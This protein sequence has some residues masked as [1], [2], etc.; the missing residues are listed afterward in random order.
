M[1]E[2]NKFVNLATEIETLST[3]YYSNLETVKTLANTNT[4][5][6]EKLSEMQKLIN[7][8]LVMLKKNMVRIED[9]TEKKVKTSSKKG[10]SL[11]DI[12]LNILEN[13]EKPLSLKE[14][15]LEVNEMIN[16]GLYS[17]TS[18][19]IGTLI[20]QSLHKLKS[21]GLVVS[22]R[23]EEQGRSFYSKTQSETIAA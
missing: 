14:I 3:E 22:E 7:N 21:K 18:D 8:E 13:G 6:L 17:T 23:D 15:T 10:N 9:M 4:S 12:I 20:S 5:L 11:G 19:K 16:S 2:T 1:L